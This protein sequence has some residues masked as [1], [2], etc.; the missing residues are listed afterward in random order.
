MVIPQSWVRTVF[1]LFA[2]SSKSDI[3]CI[4]KATQGTIDES[5]FFSRG[6]MLVSQQVKMFFT[7]SG[8][9]ERE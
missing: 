1:S 7:T 3:Q 6:K 2:L 9:G 8:A 5:D 4:V